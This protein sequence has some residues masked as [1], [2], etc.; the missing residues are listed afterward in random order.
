MVVDIWLFAAPILIAG[1]N[2]ASEAPA[3]ALA[4]FIFSYAIP[5]SLLFSRASFIRPYRVSSLN[6]LTQPLEFSL[7]S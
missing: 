3:L 6:S 2:G 4:I 1:N 5:K 7:P